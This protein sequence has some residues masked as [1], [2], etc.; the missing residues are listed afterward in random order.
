MQMSFAALTVPSIEELEATG[1]CC[2]D[3][4]WVNLCERYTGFGDLDTATTIS[5][6]LAELVSTRDRARQA[7]IVAQ[8]TKD[9]EFPAEATGGQHITIE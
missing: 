6:P 8:D 1:L 3:V 7:G 5:V 9:G 2:G 4:R